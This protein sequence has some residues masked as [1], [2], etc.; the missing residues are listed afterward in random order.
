GRAGGPRPAEPR[1]PA[2]VAPALGHEGDPHA[3]GHAEVEPREEEAE[4]GEGS[5]RSA[6]AL[7]VAAAPH[8]LAAS[9]GRAH[10]AHFPRNSFTDFESMRRMD[11]NSPFRWL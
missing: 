5:E 1:A 8:A 9:A 6:L 2:V 10:G 4:E 3:E 11:S 7:P